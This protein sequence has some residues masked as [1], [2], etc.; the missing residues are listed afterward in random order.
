[1]PR[2]VSVFT[3]VFIGIAECGCV[4]ARRGSM[5]RT[6]PPVVVRNPH[7]AQEANERGLQLAQ[8]E[9]LDRAEQAFREA[10]RA[11]AGFAAAHNNLGLVLLERR[12]FYEAA[13]EFQQASRLD[14]R[15]VEPVMNLGRLYESVGWHDAAIGQYEKARG[16]QPESV[17][18]QERLAQAFEREGR[19]SRR[20]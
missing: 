19:S 14:R 20:R 1:M 17:E 13:V 3:A 11:N 8:Q 12:R 15:A 6:G 9:Q 18:V 10:V 7:A 5:D 2:S 16:L 4:Q